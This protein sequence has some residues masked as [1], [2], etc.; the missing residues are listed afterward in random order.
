[1]PM[2][3][4]DTTT[5]YQHYT[6]ESFSSSRFT[7]L[8]E[9]HVTLALQ[10]FKSITRNYALFHISFFFLGCLELLAFVLFFSFLTKTTILAFSLAGIFLTGFSYFLL[11]FY[12]QAKKPEQLLALKHTFL[13][14]TQAIL[15]FQKKTQQ[16]HQCTIRALECLIDRLHAQ[17]YTYYA[18]FQSFQTL[19]PLMKKFSVW[20]HWKDVHQ[21]KELLFQL[22]IKEAIEL[23]KMAPTDL[24]PHAA[25]AT[26]YWALANHYLD[27]RKTD[28][29]TE[30]LFVSLEYDSAEMNEKFKKNASRAIEEFK[31]LAEYAPKDPWVHA[32]LAA[33]YHALNQ[34]EEEIQQMQIIRTLQ[35]K[36]KEVLFRLGV[37]Y[38]SQGKHAEALCLYEELQQIHANKALELLSYYDAYALD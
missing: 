16:F 17:E 13:E 37:L 33:I 18:A 22:V 9:P 38:F 1:M 6:K 23:I 7:D 5:T 25:L 4:A 19:G 12:F 21:M 34:P 29:E 14:Q 10:Q 27:P 15:P 20:C 35:P 32:Q 8:I 11:L 31:I 28:P 2:T 30:H 36:E 3:T 24:E 26:A